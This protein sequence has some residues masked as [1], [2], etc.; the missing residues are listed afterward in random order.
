[1]SD[2]EFE[3]YLTLIGR[4][5]R[6]SSAQR[7]AIGEELRDH[8]ESRLAELINR[9]F[10]HTQAVQLALEE[11]GDAAGLAARFS[12]ISQTR[13]R[14]LI[15]RCTLASVIGLA[16][17]VLVALALWPDN[18]APKMID[19]AAADPNPFEADHSKMLASDSPK[20]SAAQKNV[21]KP[22]KAAKAVASDAEMQAALN[23]ITTIEFQGT[24]LSDAM[25]FLA[26]QHHV[27]IIFDTGALKGAGLDQST[28]Q[29]T[30]RVQDIQLKTALDLI[31]HEWNLTYMVHDGFMEITT[32][33]KADSTLVTRVY[34]CQAILSAP[35]PVMS[36]F[37][38]HAEKRA[39]GETSGATKADTGM[40]AKTDAKAAGQGNKSPTPAV[41]NSPAD[42][43][44]NVMTTTVAPSSWD[45][46]GGPGSILYYKGLLIICQT[47]DVHEQVATLL[48]QIS[49]KIARSAPTSSAPLAPALPGANTAGGTHYNGAMPTTFRGTKAT[50]ILNMRSV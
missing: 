13:N 26:D 42:E 39:S 3:N 36:N 8:F 15:M 46:Q 6:L 30:L 29:I 19:R 10:S 34:D 5:L 14:R 49:S 18:H 48:D 45:G 44:I 21:D 43:L 47:Y 33:E 40:E 17:A 25:E 20:V 7:Q 50:R 27:Q 4:L 2:R 9:G 1:M 28:L 32:K 41:A 11:F 16:A 23:D 37:V 31:L 22:A 24:P 12:T 35:D 38:L